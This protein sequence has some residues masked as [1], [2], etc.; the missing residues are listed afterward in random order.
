MASWL[1]LGSGYHSNGPETQQSW[2]ENISLCLSRTYCFPGLSLS[3][4][5]LLLLPFYRQRN[6]NFQALKKNFSRTKK[7]VSGRAEF[8][9]QQPGSMEKWEVRKERGQYVPK[10]DL[11]LSWKASSSRLFILHN[12]L[13]I[14]WMLKYE[15][16]LQNCKKLHRDKLWPLI[17]PPNAFQWRKCDSFRADILTHPYPNSGA[18]CKNVG[19]K[20]V[21]VCWGFGELS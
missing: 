18:I 11:F 2:S 19:A 16:I 6:Q 10:I 20:H 15:M 9:A 3:R 12:K 14:V 5:T 1:S 8:W 17:I 21:C 13:D 7:P 4:W